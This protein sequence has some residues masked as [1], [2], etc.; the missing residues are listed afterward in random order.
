[1]PNAL[2]EAVDKSTA[3][4]DSVSSHPSASSESIA[5]KGIKLRFQ[6]LSDSVVK[7]RGTVAPEVLQAKFQLL[8]DSVVK[9][10]RLPKAD[11]DNYREVSVAKR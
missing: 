2:N 8:S 6:L 1:M 7:C 10:R 5:Q 9:C 4:G 3:R 11:Y